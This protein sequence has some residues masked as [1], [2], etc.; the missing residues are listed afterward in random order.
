MNRNGKIL[1]WSIAGISFLTLLSK[2]A[3][4]DFAF[5]FTWAGYPTIV[6]ALPTMGIAAIIILIIETLVVR[7]AARAG[8]GLSLRITLIMNLFSTLVGGIVWLMINN[9][10]CIA[11][12]IIIILPL[13]LLP[14]F[15]VRARWSCIVMRCG[16]LA[17]VAGVFGIVM[18]NGAKSASVMQLWWIIIG[19]VT[20]GFGLSIICEYPIVNLYL[21]KD[22][23]NRTVILANIASYIF[24]FLMAPF[25]WP[26]PVMQ[27]YQ[28]YPD[29]YVM[30]SEWYYENVGEKIFHDVYKKDLTTP[31]L[32]GII[33]DP[34]VVE[35]SDEE[36]VVEVLWKACPQSIS[37]Q[38]VIIGGSARMRNLKIYADL[39]LSRFDLPEETRKEIR[40]IRLYVEMLPDVS[41]AV[42][43]R[44]TD[45]LKA[46]YKEWD[47]QETSI[48]IKSLE[49][50]GYVVDKIVIIRHLAD[51]QHE[52]N[53]A[54]RKAAREI[55][56]L[57]EEP[58]V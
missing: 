53:P 51:A 57:Y 26:N 47:A 11:A 44:D 35:P 54:I 24:I 43:E 28:M 14:M 32:L 5:G 8:W 3:Y 17:I 39:A 31:Q 33:K 7:W 20:M 34:G 6:A 49:T 56:A 37:D 29:S 15:V 1:Y 46:L 25:F 42:V 2:P 22:E 21:E 45:K 36:Y 10:F 40:W 19:Q 50:G 41:A 52:T 48:G 13:L 30:R 18:I 23:D 4:A 38:D 27:Q 16:F 12:V 9:T 58:F 55:I